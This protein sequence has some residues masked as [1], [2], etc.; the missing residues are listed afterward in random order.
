M[1]RI[2]VDAQQVPKELSGVARLVEQIGAAV[3]DPR[4]AGLPIT[5]RC[6]QDVAPTLAAMFPPGIR[7]VAP[8]PQSRPVWRRLLR[9]Q[10]VQPLRDG[11]DTILICPGDQG[12][13]WGRAR[14]VLLSNDVRRLVRP[15]TAGRAERLFYR[16]IQ[17][18]SI[19]RADVVLT[20]S[21][22]SKD[23]I[24]RATGRA[25]GVTVVAIH[26][27]P[28]ADTPSEAA[29][30]AH[31]LAVS[32]VRPYKGFD[33]LVEAVIALGDRAPR[34]V[35]VG[36]HD[37]DV[38]PLRA[39]L[40]EHGM[41]ERVDFRGW[42]S[43]DELQTLYRTAYATVCP[44][45]YEGYGLPVAESLAQGVPV[46]AS[47]IPPH[48]EVGGDAVR[49]FRA[50]DAGDLTRVLGALLDAPEER[51]RLARAALDRSRALARRTP[52]WPQAIGDAIAAVRDRAR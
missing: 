43:E 3:A 39:R 25:E 7:V 2:V 20:I 28:V 51:A 19:R 33:H 49:Y 47:D 46:V 11:R 9:Q 44:S 23:E 41:E 30:G 5:L 1:T 52:R 12:P 40:R 34:T 36:S 31:L 32:A 26:P 22:F 37:I 8:L 50:G 24:A 27:E 4:I 14:V 15:D 10:L 6:A 17:P 38:E 29:P 18:P 45:A 48:T 42:V 21:E 16:L 13:L 35:I